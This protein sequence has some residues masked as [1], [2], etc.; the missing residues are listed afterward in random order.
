MRKYLFGLLLCTTAAFSQQVVSSV[1][2]KL[3][4]DRSA[5]QVVDTAASQVALFVSDK[6]TTR[7]LLLDSKMNIVDSIS[8]QRPDKDFTELLGS[9]GPAQKPTLFWGAGTSKKKIA[10]QEF[11]FD[12][13]TVV[14][15]NSAIDLKE[16]R[17]IQKLSTPDAFYLVTVVKKSNIMKF[18]V[19]DAMGNMKERVINMDG[20]R[21]FRS[22]TGRSTLYG[23]ME[24]IFGGFEGPFSLKKIDIDSPT[25]LTDS[26]NKRKCYLIGDKFYITND[27]NVDY[28]QLITIDLQNFTAT[29]KFLKQP[30]IASEY[31]DD[32]NSNSFL[33]GDKLYQIKLASDQM[34]LTLKDF[35][36]NVI[37]EH[38]VLPGE[39]MTFKNSPIRQ[40]GGDL[41]G[42][43]IL[44]KTSQFTRKV[45]NSNS[46]ISGYSIN[47]NTLVTI[48]SVT[49]AS[50]EGGAMAIGGM[51]GVAGVLIAYAVSN[52]TMDNFN[53][54]A[55]RKVV[56]VDC[57]FDANGN[58]IAGPTPK[59]AFEKIRFYIEDKEISGETMYRFG[60]DYYFG[61]YDKDG[62]VYTIRKFTDD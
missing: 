19:F 18:Y 58:H 29:E 40:E 23:V 60:K 33:T 3:K 27:A 47:G 62:T 7:A 17:I 61:F 5:F 14:A 6:A 36:D 31:R 48:G 52:P 51:F 39:E 9:A 21:F 24:Q 8:V 32:L 25:A 22:D 28:T 4:R 35:Q 20:F 10:S 57:L 46:G 42:S 26:A 37:K 44:D 16:E 1:N 59:L 56:Y 43:R 13:N 54:Y 15:K 2:V 49:T 55:N 50:P 34:Y 41:D 11:D 45:N 30:F 12:A 53:A 38:K